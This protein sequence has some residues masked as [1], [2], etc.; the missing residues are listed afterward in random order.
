MA[1]YPEVSLKIE[2]HTDSQGSEASNQKLSEKRSASVMSYFL[3]KGIS[4]S[5]LTS[6]GYGE[7]VP[8]ADNNTAEGRK[9][10][11]RVDIRANY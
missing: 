4:S 5:R 2:G 3:G 7:T 9:H 10:N 11:R 1:R 6:V 8:I